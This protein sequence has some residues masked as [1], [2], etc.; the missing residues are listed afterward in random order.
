MNGDRLA[1]QKFNIF[2]IV[3][4]S[5]SMRGSRINQVNQAISDI[6]NHLKDM[7]FDNT[8]VDFYLSILTFSTEANWHMGQKEFKIDEFKFDEIKA[9]GQTNLHLAYNELSDVL[10]K[11]SKGGMMP[12]FGGVA[13][14]IILLTD[15]HPVKDNLKNELSL[16]REQPWFNVAL[17]YGVAIEQDDERTMKVLADF[18]SGNGDVIKVYDS[19]ILNQI[20]KIIVMTASK[21][22]ST[23]NTVTDTKYNSVDA[24]IKQEIYDALDVV[25]KWG[26]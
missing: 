4:T 10:K 9:K 6:S 7:Q 22:K 5:S 1:K 26:W 14:I 24:Q 12:D 19:N 2:L 18:V 17:K 23:S 15:G 3:D 20:I 11:E 21:V 16:L 8:N 25:D 13:P